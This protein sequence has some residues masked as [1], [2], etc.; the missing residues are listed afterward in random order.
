MTFGNISDLAE[1]FLAELRNGFSTGLIRQFI[2]RINSTASYENISAV[3]Y[4]SG[5]AQIAGAFSVGY[6]G[7]VLYSPT[8]S[9]ANWSI[10]ACMPTDLRQ[11]PWKYTRDRRDFSEVLFIN[12]TISADGRV[13]RNT[14]PIGGLLYRVTLNTTAG[15][16]ELPNYMNGV[17]AG[18][19]L[20]KDLNSICGHNCTAEGGDP[21]DIL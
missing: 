10:Q 19:L 3:E 9:A 20:D 8:D 6:S 17:T 13:P 15:Y 18:P 12:V 7:K 11:S 16:F 14:T 2:P 21:T 1:P 4:P 5:C